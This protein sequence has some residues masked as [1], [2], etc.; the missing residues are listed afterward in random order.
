MASSTCPT[1]G[2][3]D[4][5]DELAVALSQRHTRRRR[6]GYQPP[7]GHEW[8]NRPGIATGRQPRAGV[9]AR[10]VRE[11]TKYAVQTSLAREHVGL[12]R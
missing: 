2:L 1:G 10:L 4:A 3:V 12:A 7:R 6:D 8:V 11:L 9:E 5:P